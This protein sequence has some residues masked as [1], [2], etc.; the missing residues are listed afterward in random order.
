MAPTREL[1]ASHRLVRSVLAIAAAAAVSGCGSAPG[2]VTVTPAPMAPDASDGVVAEPGTGLAEDTAW[3]RMRFD[4]VQA[5]E[6]GTLGAGTVAAVDLVQQRVNSEALVFPAREVIGPRKGLVVTIGG[7]GGEENLLTAIDATSG[8]RRE[9]VRTSDIIVDAVFASGTTVVFLTADPRTGALTGTWRVDAAAPAQPEPVEGL[10]GEVPDIQLV[11]RSA[12]HSRLLASPTGELVAAVH[13]TAAGA[14]ALRAVNLVEGTRYEGPLALGE[15]PVALAGERVVMRPLCQADPCR[16]ELLD[17]ASGERAPI[18]DVG[19]APHFDEAVLAS[20][21]GPLL[22]R[23][24]SGNPMQM[25][26]APEPPTFVVTHLEG[27]RSGAPVAVALETMRIVR[28]Q[29]LDVGVEL[30]PG[31]FAVMGP[32]PVAGGAGPGVAE[33]IFAVSASDGEVVPLRALGEFL[34]QG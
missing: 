5:I 29:S 27:L 12:P 20:E 21:D 1:A 17:L 8:D 13:C 22:V 33:A 2:P 7:S 28:A 34:S 14:C 19:S 3:W 15:E 16:G 23:Q 11:A 10:I 25:E 9:V 32:A 26:G 30:P 6:V 4:P 31:W 18:P 24:L